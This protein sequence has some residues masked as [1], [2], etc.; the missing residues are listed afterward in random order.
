MNLG[1]DVSAWPIL[2][3]AIIVIAVILLII[4]LFINQA[5]TNAMGAVMP[6][7]EY[8]IVDSAV[9]S[10]ALEIMWEASPQ[11]MFRSDGKGN[12]VEGNQAYLDFWGF[13]HKSQIR[14]LEWYDQVED[15]HNGHAEQLMEIVALREPWT[16]DTVLLEREDIPLSG[17]T[18]R[19]IG[20]PIWRDPVIKEEFLG[21]S[22]VVLDL[23][24]RS[25]P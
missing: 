21:Y 14:T 18:I 2:I 24:D 19:F 4:R 23:G 10:A 9:H 11:A 17:H 25:K 12:M 15:M 3:A 22:G 16:Y 1:S 8:H 6:S 5:A 20:Q 7:M 13:R